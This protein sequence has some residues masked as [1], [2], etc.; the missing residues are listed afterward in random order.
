MG[1]ESGVLPGPG[2]PSPGGNEAAAI[3]RD[4]ILSER[5]A[6]LHERE[7]RADER[8]ARLAQWARELGTAARGRRDSAYQNLRR[9]RTAVDISQGLKGRSEASERHARDLR[10]RVAAA[11]A[12]LVAT[13]EEIA[14]VHDVLASAR[15]GNC[16]EFR[17][18]AANARKAAH[19]AREIEHQFS[20]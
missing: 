7:R 18:I 6:R 2:S 9:P 19:R 16:D 10:R 4:A 11:A 1:P 12:D 8:E 5:E 15:P 14:R 3:E 13:E 17:R 20:D